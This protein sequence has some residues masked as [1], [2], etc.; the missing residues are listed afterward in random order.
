M[1]NITDATGFGFGA[2]VD[3]NNRIHAHS[4][5]VAESLQGQS[6]NINTGTIAISADSALLYFQNNEPEDFVIT[7][8]ALGNDGT[9]TAATGS[10]PS[11]T[12]IRNPTGGT[13]ISTATPVDQNQNRNFGDS[14]TLDALAYKGASGL[15]ITGGDEIALLQASAVGRD[16]YTIDFILP[17]GSSIGIRY[18]LNAAFTG[19]ADIYAAIIGYVRD[20][21]GKDE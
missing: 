12:L 15:T 19:P 16:F 9:G 8:I 18:N 14:T 10:R 21:A 6:Y 3:E 11:I 1:A 2:R 20:P 4:V 5:T 17:R 7:G 13:I